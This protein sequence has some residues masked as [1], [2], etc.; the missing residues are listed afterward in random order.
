VDS[1]GLSALLGG[2]EGIRSL[3]WSHHLFGLYVGLYGVSAVGCRRTI[4]S[5]GWNDDI[6]GFERRYH[7]LRLGL[8]RDVITEIRHTPH[9]TFFLGS[10]ILLGPP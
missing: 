10:T 5:P 2:D 4:L 9:T 1:S 7:S 6:T 3:D 8:E